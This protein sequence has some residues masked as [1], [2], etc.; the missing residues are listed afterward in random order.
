MVHATRSA[1]ARALARLLPVLLYALCAFLMTPAPGTAVPPTA[2][3]AAQ[4]PGPVAPDTHVSDTEAA[5]LP[6]VVEQSVRFPAPPV[7]PPVVR[8]ADSAPV[9]G[10]VAGD[11]RRE[12]APPGLPHHP[13]APRGPPSTRHS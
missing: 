13:R 7:A 3:V 5:E 9:H 1:S 8:T 2:V 10:R 4:P 6:A 11:P 12:R